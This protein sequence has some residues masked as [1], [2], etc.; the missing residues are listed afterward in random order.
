MAL[1]VW[2]PLNGNLRNQGQRNVTTAVATGI[3]NN[4][5]KIGKCYSCT[6]NKYLSFNYTINTTDTF[7]LS[8]WFKIPQSMSSGN[9]WQQLF[10]FTGNDGSDKTIPCNWAPYNQMKF[11]D[12]STQQYLWLTV[13]Y[14]TWMH[15]T[16]TN[17]FSGGTNYITFYK[18]GVKL[19]HYTKDTA[20]NIKSGVLKLGAG[21]LADYGPVYFNDFRIY[22]HCL[23]P[24]EVQDIYLG[25]VFEFSSPWK[26]FGEISNIGDASGI[27]LGLTPYN[28]S[29]SGSSMY[30][31]GSSSYVQFNGLGISGGTVS[32]W[33]NVAAKPTSQRII[34]CDPSSKM[35]VGFL[36]NGNILASSRGVSTATYQTTGITW[37]QMTHVVAV[38]NSGYVQTAL[39][40]NGVQPATAS[41]SDWT[42]SGNIASIGRR[43]GSGTADYLNGFVNKIEVFA[44]QLTAAD[45]QALYQKGPST[46]SWNKVRPMWSGLSQLNDSGCTWIR[47]LHHNTP[48]TKLFTTGN[49]KNH[50]EADLFSKLYLYDYP[51]LLK[52]PDGTF[53]FMA[54]EKL[55]SSSTEQTFRW[56]QTSNPTAA[57]CTGYLQLANSAGVNRAFGLASGPVSNTLFS[58]KNGW[59]CA[60]GCNLAYQGGIPGFGDVVKTGYMDLY[61]RIDGTD[62]GAYL[63]PNDYQRLEYIESTGTSYINTGTKFNPETDSCKLTF[64]GNDMSNNGMMLASN[65]GK[66]F[67]LYYYSAGINVYADNGSGQQNVAGITRDLNKHSVEWR[68]KH[69]YFDGTDKGTL[70]NSYTET[71][72][73]IWLF[74]YGSNG[75]PFKGRIYYAEICRSG[76]LNRVFI[77]AKRKS[78][79]AVGMYD[80]VNSVFY[81]SN[82]TAFIAGPEI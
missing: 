34:Y 40:I 4:S 31:N 45:V 77:P 35:I 78:D 66:Y 14:D 7:S 55:L 8:F 48:A 53:E 69:S 2:L 46:N 43:L 18:D 61:A 64:K 67:W 15:F 13:P 80:L 42:N 51:N 27:K 20:L 17:T 56:R 39:Y 76:V 10:S 68:G 57:T 23:S 62:F 63:L 54:K 12:V 1:Q 25:K 41:T 29:V 22:N 24:K 70:S 60:C 32:A 65:G 52:L 82:N 9:S 38:W 28:L 16:V 50:E 75:Y 21:V 79:G 59:W 73:N 58:N 5:G 33:I 81:Q 71:T 37:G 19:N 6:A 36:A 72:N 26:K 3:V 74:S 47:L 49:R 44:T 30:F 11:F